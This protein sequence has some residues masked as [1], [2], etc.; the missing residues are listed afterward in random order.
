MPCYRRC[1]LELKMCFDPMGREVASSTATVNHHSRLGSRTVFT[2]PSLL[3][4]IRCVLYF[5]SSVYRLLSTRMDVVN[6]GCVQHTAPRAPPCYCQAN[7]LRISISVV[8]GS[9]VLSFESKYFNSN[10][11]NV[12]HNMMKMGE[13]CELE[14]FRGCE[15]RRARGVFTVFGHNALHATNERR[16]VKTTSWDSNSAPKLQSRSYPLGYRRVSDEVTKEKEY[17]AKWI[18]ASFVLVNPSAE[19]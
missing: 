18:A 11:L 14:T 15:V 8:T 5:R 12:Y 3:E 19:L 4:N 10:V 2:D 16:K 7:Q 9:G 1:T 13:F 6:G 17:I